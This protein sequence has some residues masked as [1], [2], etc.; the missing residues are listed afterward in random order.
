M[1]QV[2]V[3]FYFSFS[4]KMRLESTYISTT[5]SILVGLQT[6][7]CSELS[8]ENM[9]FIYEYVQ[10]KSEFQRQCNGI[11]KIPKRQSHSVQRSM[12]CRSSLVSPSISLQL[13]KERSNSLRIAQNRTADE[14]ITVDF[15]VEPLSVETESR[16]IWSGVKKHTEALNATRFASYIFNLNGTIFSR[17]VLPANLPKSSLLTQRSKF[18]DRLYLLYLKYIVRGTITLCFLSS[19]LMMFLE[20]VWSQWIESKDSTISMISIQSIC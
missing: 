9:L 17:V 6:T 5:S 4:L 1:L 13:T 8:S 10:I 2:T 12:S 7:K 15:N 16:S 3:I 20:F 19:E 14:Y 11:V 18:I